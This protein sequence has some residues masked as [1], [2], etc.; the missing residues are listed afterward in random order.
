VV[1]SLE[2]ED[3]LMEL[4]DAMKARRS[5]R[6]FKSD[7]VPETLITQ[8]IEAARLAPSGSNVQP[9]RF[10]VI[11]SDAVRAQLSDATPLPFVSQAPVVIACCVDAESLGGMATRAREL[12]EAIEDTSRAGRRLILK[13]PDQADRAVLHLA[14]RTYARNW[15]A[16]EA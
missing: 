7:P 14:R 1:K 3:V 13:V 9:T 10:V 11:K 8:L 16:V 6:K 4:L 2:K 12:K 5:I 15:L